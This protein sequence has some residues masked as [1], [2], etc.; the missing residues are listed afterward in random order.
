NLNTTQDHF[1]KAARQERGCCGWYSWSLRLLALEVGYDVLREVPHR[2]GDL[3]RWREE[4]EVLHAG[5]GV[6]LELAY[7]LGGRPCDG[8]RLTRPLLGFPRDLQRVVGQVLQ[9]L[10][11][12][13]PVH[14]TQLLP[15]VSPQPH[16]VEYLRPEARDGPRQEPGALHRFVVV[17]S[18]HRYELYDRFDRARLPAE[19]LG[20]VADGLQP[21]F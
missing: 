3:R 5:P 6:A 16:V 8:D 20:C 19:P 2:G 21:F 17:L 18:Y 1:R 12:T 10:L 9:V 11:R 15:A 14:Q 13:G 7:H 4:G